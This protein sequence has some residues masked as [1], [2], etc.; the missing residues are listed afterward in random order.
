MAASLNKQINAELYSSYLYLSMAAWFASENLSGF[1]H[2]MRKQAS[3][4]QAHAMKFYD[5]L[6]E[7]GA[8]VAL[9]AIDAPPASW[10]SPLAAFEEVSKH[11][12]KVTALIEGL[13]AQADELKDRATAVLLHWYINEQ[14]EEEAHAVEIVAKLKMIKDSAG[15]LFQMDHHLGKRE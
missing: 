7:R 15:G 6:I 8:K 2:W 3:E 11:E 1:A 9:T 14:V 10:K 12:S 5:Y 13:A 4:E